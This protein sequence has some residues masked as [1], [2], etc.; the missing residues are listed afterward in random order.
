[1][2]AQN[3]LIKVSEEIAGTRVRLGAMFADAEKAEG[4][5]RDRLATSIKSTNDG[6]TKLIDRAT[7]LKAEAEVERLQRDAMKAA[8]SSVSRQIDPAD[9]NPDGSYASK[10]RIPG[11]VQAIKSSQKFADYHGGSTDLSLD[12]YLRASLSGDWSNVPDHLVSGGFAGK[13]MGLG[14]LGTLTLPTV[15]T[16]RIIDLSR[17]ASR[18]VQAGA[19]TAR[20]DSGSETIARLTQDPTADWKT[21]NALITASDASFEPINLVAR[22]LAARVVMSVELADDAPS[23]ANAIES[24]LSASLA[25][26]LDRAALLGSGTPPEPRGLVNTS[27][28]FTQ[29]VCLGLP[30][31]Y[32]DF[33]RA[34]QRIR[35]ANGEP[36]AVIMGPDVAGELERLTDLDGNPLQPPDSF[37]E[38]RKLT[39]TKVAG[40][41]AI[42][43]GASSS[44]PC[45]RSSGSRRLVRPTT[46]TGWA[47]RATACSSGRRCGPISRSS[48]L[49]ISSC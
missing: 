24:S 34:V 36:N 48:D 22:T 43:D 14:A 1:M 10:D 6:L 8:R 27:G 30:G 44:S 29:D 28:V 49:R 3:E 15:L 39:T 11:T 42:G 25:A 31:G 46:R 45:G 5:E 33:C 38:L 9:E 35:E 32:A 4:P 2:T 21:E 47:S 26:E 23:I 13:T 12:T 40:D 20:M 19:L 18:V 16:N 17:A 7:S 41:A 37:R